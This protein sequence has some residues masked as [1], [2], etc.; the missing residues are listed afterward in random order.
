MGS[1][2]KKK[3]RRNWKLKRSHRTTGIRYSWEPTPSPTSWPPATTLPRSS[4]SQT[5]IKVRFLPTPD[6][7]AHNIST[8][9][10]SLTHNSNSRVSKESLIRSADAHNMT[11]R[12]TKDPQPNSLILLFAIHKLNTYSSFSLD[13]SAAVRLALGETQLVAETRKFLETNGVYLDAF[14]KVIILI[15]IIY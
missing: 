13:T 7:D 4:C 14:S 1:H 5:P 2:L 12:K 9:S 15:V 3:K 6:H 8:L 11:N 10:I